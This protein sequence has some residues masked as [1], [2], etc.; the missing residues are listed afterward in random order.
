MKAAEIDLALQNATSVNYLQK[1]AALAAAGPFMNNPIDYQ[2]TVQT[3]MLGAGAALPGALETARHFKAASRILES[4]NNADYGNR[5]E[6]GKKRFGKGAFVKQTA[7]A[8]VEALVETFDDIDNPWGPV[9]PEVIAGLVPAAAI[10]V[11][12]RRKGKRRK[13]KQEKQKGQ[14]SARS[15]RARLLAEQR[16][17]NSRR[18]SNWGW[19]R[20]LPR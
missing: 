4:T 2:T 12:A 16:R 3:A 9:P 19:G 20:L 13:D 10:V 18:G 15:E 17:K 7:G 14:E 6:Y 1:L 5:L 11:A 8:G